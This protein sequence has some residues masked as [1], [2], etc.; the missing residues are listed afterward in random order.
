MAS[1]ASK[2]RR[3]AIKYRNSCFRILSR[4]SSSSPR[5]GVRIRVTGL[6]EFELAWDFPLRASNEKARTDRSLSNIVEE[7]PAS[8]AMEFLSLPLGFL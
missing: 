3:I 4:K 5:I 8:L 7:V 2:R 1:K 6:K